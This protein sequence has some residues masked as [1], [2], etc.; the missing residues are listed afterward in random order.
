MVTQGPGGCDKC[1]ECGGPLVSGGHPRLCWDCDQRDD[2]DGD[3]GDEGD[4]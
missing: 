4:D 1:T 2:D 3:D